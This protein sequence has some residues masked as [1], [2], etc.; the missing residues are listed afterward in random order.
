MFQ[1]GLNLHVSLVAPQETAK[2]AVVIGWHSD[3]I[4]RHFPCVPGV[5]EHIKKLSVRLQFRCVAFQHYETEL[6]NIWSCIGE[7][8]VSHVEGGGA[9]G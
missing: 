5:D 2:M 8:E 6:C 3:W 7:A 4:N 1:T 9:F